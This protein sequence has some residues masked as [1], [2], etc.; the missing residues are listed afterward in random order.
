MIS[1]S[2]ILMT[3]L[4]TVV[5]FAHWAYYDERDGNIGVVER[6]REMDE[7]TLETTAVCLKRRLEYE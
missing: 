5:C 2:V 3:E 6:A 1:T 4:K 7:G